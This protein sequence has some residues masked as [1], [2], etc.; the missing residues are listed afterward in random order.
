[1]LRFKG[2][3]HP[4]EHK[5]TAKSKIVDITP[6]SIVSIPLY[7]KKPVISQG[8]WVSVGDP[9]TFD[10]S[11]H[12]SISGRVAEISD[13][14]VV[15]ESDDNMTKSI[16]VRPFTKKLTDA[17]ADDLSQHIFKLGIINEGEFL[18]DIIKS[19]SEK[20]SILIISCGE[21]EPFLCA[22]H[23]C[24]TENAR[25]VLFG[26]KILMKALGLKKIVFTFSAN[27]RKQI[28]AFKKMTFNLPYVSIERHS[29][30]YP[31]DRKE[32]LLRS[33]IVAHLSQS[34]NLCR[35][36]F[37]YVR[38]SVCAAVFEGFK[39]GTPAVTKTITVDGDKV[40]KPT[41]LRV[42][43]GTSIK[44]VLEKTYANL[45]EHSKLINGGPIS[46]SQISFDGYVENNTKSLIALGKKYTSYT[47]GECI[48]CDSCHKVCPEGL[49]PMIF[50]EGKLHGASKCISCG[51]CSYVCPAKLDFSV[52]KEV[53]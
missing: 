19:K 1:M 31:A 48:Y 11:S 16:A 34:S 23:R 46:G 10:H 24:V 32:I 3:I 39:S 4:D 40:L 33:Y 20:A 29:T 27:Q 37:V 9:L 53:K 13:D 14:R 42:P 44:Y 12:A 38:P 26:S 25:E 50:N 18:S 21:T 51:S 49:Y 28:R 22:E 41:T 6:P 43:I 8:D 36:S 17:S 15:I 30:K 7:G 5:Y 2:G 47:I 45:D 35:D 52:E